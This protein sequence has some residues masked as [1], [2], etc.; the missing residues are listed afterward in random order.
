MLLCAMFKISNLTFT[1]ETYEI[2]G[3]SS[4]FLIPLLEVNLATCH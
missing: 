2:S 1:G 3:D 4:P